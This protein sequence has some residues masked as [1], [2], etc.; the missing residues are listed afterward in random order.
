MNDTAVPAR[1]SSLASAGWK[2]V[3]AWRPRASH[4]LTGYL[5]ALMILGG[6]VLRIQNVGYP[7]RQS[8][9]EPQ[10]VAAA[11]QFLIGAPDVGECC[12]PPLGKL[13][14]GVGMLMVGNNP[15]GWRFAPLCFGLFSIVLVYFIASAL[16]EDRRAGWFAAAFMAADGFFLSYSRAALPDMSLACFVL[17]SLLAAI[18][19]RGWA[20]VLACAVLVGLAASIKWVGLLVGLPACFAILLLRRAPWYSIVSFAVVP[21]VHLA[22]WMIGLALIGHPNG[23]MDVLAEM[24][25]RGQIHLGFAHGVNPLE[26]AWYTWLVLYHP[27]VIKSAQVGAKFDSLPA[28]ATRCSG[29]PR[30]CASWRCPCWGRGGPSPRWRERWRGWFDVRTTQALAILGVSWVSM[31]LLWFTRRITTY[32]YHYLTPWG[33]ALVLLGG[34]AARLDRRY[35]EE[36]LCSCWWCWR[37]S[38]TSRRF[39]P[40]FPSRSLPR[41]GGSSSRSGS[42]LATEALERCFSVK[43]CGGSAGLQRRG[44]SSR[45]IARSPSTSS[46]RS[47][48]S[49]IEAPTTRLAVA[50]ALGIRHVIQ[51][52]ANRGYGGNQKT[53][54][55]TALALGA[56]IVVMLHPDYQYTPKL[57]RAMVGVLAEDVYD[58]VLARASWATARSRAACRSTNT[59]PTARSP[60]SRTSSRGRS[61]PST[62]PAFAPTGGRS[63]GHPLRSQL[64]RLHLRQPVPGAGARARFSNRRAD[65]PDQVLRRGLEHQFPPKPS[66]R[67]PLLHDGSAVPAASHGRGALSALRTQGRAA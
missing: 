45:P 17:W 22:V 15:A 67:N 25:R 35:P 2:A 37:S 51:H 39:G 60:R 62:T 44:R 18:T 65:L 56:E 48:W 32:W 29:S 61:S 27:I 12:H 16:F 8:F 31:M 36:V 13:L 58:V 64:G 1:A 9:D 3:V 21:F 30:T 6:V 41:T 46:M 14:I 43:D 19:A 53:C 10:Y 26:S 4:P 50:K 11:H 34:V 24:R 7:F 52:D 47:C 63:G 42:R 20:G 28:S 33:I 54:Y 5:L 66:L 23:P 38:S 40:R 59:S 57:V 49:T 55:D